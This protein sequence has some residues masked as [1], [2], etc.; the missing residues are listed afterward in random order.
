VNLWAGAIVG[1][2]AYVV[3]SLLTR[4][5]PHPWIPF[6][7][8]LIAVGFAF[9]A[10]FAAN[11]WAMLGMSAFDL[12]RG[13]LAKKL[14]LRLPN[15]MPAERHMWQLVSHM[16]VYRSRESADRLDLY[17]DAGEPA[18]TCKEKRN[19]AAG[20]AQKSG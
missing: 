11:D 3:L 13:D 6:V 17:R 2:V 19:T 1:I 20:A 5:L 16:I 12:F 8:A 18:E 4:T 10:R 15:Y 7:C 14:G 9:T